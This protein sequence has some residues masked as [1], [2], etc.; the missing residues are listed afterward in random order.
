MP[1]IH[2]SKLETERKSEKI[3][4]QK[5][6]RW[7]DSAAWTVKQTNLNMLLI[8]LLSFKV[9]RIHSSIWSSDSI[10]TSG[11]TVGWCRRYAHYLQVRAKHSLEPLFLLPQIRFMSLLPCNDTKETSNTLTCIYML[12]TRAIPVQHY[13]WFFPLHNC[14]CCCCPYG[15][16][17]QPP[18]KNHCNVI[19]HRH[20][21]AGN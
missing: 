4:K 7:L 12:H 17:S 6:D 13:L 3:R 15:S 10:F 18:I 14:E 9:F 19:I 11:C 21:P 1:Q 2:K 16:L 8:I 5:D 20:R